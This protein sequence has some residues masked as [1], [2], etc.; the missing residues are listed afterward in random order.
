MEECDYAFLNIILTVGTT[1]I[2]SSHAKNR[3]EI[4]IIV[5]K[6]IR[7]N[8]TIEAIVKCETQKKCVCG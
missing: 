1:I 7:E 6:R 2:E 8:R 4:P 5:L 3:Q